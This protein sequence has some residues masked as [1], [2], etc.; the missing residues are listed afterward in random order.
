MA[1]SAF[2]LLRGPVAQMRHLFSRERLPFTVAYFGSMLLTLISSLVYRSYLATLG[3][4]VVQLA[5]VVWCVFYG[6]RGCAECQVANRV[7]SL[8]LIFRRRRYFVSYLPGGTSG[9]RMG[10]RAVARSVLPI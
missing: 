6:G 7:R 1:L 5:A 10:T 9:L 2:A 3:S 8:C 4:A